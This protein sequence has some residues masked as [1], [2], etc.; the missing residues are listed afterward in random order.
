MLVKQAKVQFFRW[1]KFQLLDFIEN[2]KDKSV[3]AND[4]KLTC[5]V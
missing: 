3:S 4:P 5:Y 2:S 1:I